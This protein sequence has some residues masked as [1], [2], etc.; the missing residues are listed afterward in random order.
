MSILFCF[1]ALICV[2]SGRDTKPLTEEETLQLFSEYQ[3][4]FNRQYNAVEYTQKYTNF[5][6]SLARIEKLN[7]G[8]KHAKFALNKFSDMTTEEFDRTRKMPKAA[9]PVLTESCLAN[10]VTA[11]LN[12]SPEEINALPDSWDWRTTG[13]PGNKGIITPVKD[14]GSDSFFFFCFFFSILFFSFFH[15]SSF[16]SSFSF[17][18]DL[19]FSFWLPFS[20]FFFFPFVSF[21]LFFS[22]SFFK[23]FLEEPVVHA[24]PFQP[25][26]VSK[27]IGQRKEIHLL[28]FQ[29]NF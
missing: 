27:V 22:I 5:K 15:Y 20:V 3:R 26:E 23:S 17:P 18:F 9:G 28:H 11:T 12:Y 1:C 29:N 4:D 10:G 2:I 7:A 16:P 14:Q 25:L 6:A 21:F 24:G 19:L 13:G 8:S